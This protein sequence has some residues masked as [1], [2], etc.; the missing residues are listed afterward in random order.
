ME[1]VVV[2]PQVY[3]SINNTPSRWIIFPVEPASVASA[4]KLAGHSVTG[5]DLNLLPQPTESAL[6]TKIE[7]IKPD[8]VVFIP[9]WLGRYDMKA[10]DPASFNTVKQAHPNCIRINTG[11][12]ATLYPDMELKSGLPFEYGLR[13]EVEETLVELLDILDK[14]GN[15]A[16]IPG[17]FY[18]ADKSEFISEKIPSF[19]LKRM[20]AVDETVFPRRNYLDRVERG[21]FRFPRDGQPLTYN[22]TSRGCHYRC[23]FCSVIYLR[24][25]SFRQK[26]MDVIFTEIEN[27]LAAG[28]KEVHFLDELFGSNRTFLE[29]F[30]TEVKRRGLE[31]NW[32]AT[33]G[34]PVGYLDLELLKR[35]EES[36]MYRVKIPF[37]SANSRVLNKLLKKPN[38]VAQGWDV[39]RAVKKTG[40]ETIA[41]FLVGMPG[42]SKKE[43][44]QT[45]AMAQDIGFDYTL[46][47]IATPMGGSQLERE[48]LEHGLA[49]RNEIREKIRGDS[50]FFETDELKERDLFEVR[51]KI[52]SDINFAT[53]AKVRKIA[54]MFG[55]SENEA[56]KMEEV[57]RQ[58]FQKYTKA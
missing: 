11:V 21:N 26:R 35:L 39:A 30:C 14:G 23:K 50:V 33:C 29:Q 7:S 53:A 36:G 32:F 27:S 15:V 1:V 55:I 18:V 58:R 3:N 13:G 51:W 2:V 52:W 25:Y 10:V 42:E 56:A 57:A 22:Q 19:D 47:S 46:F 28:A 49:N 34:L 4:I 44:A 31:F 5:I 54:K 12:Q 43:M 41:A 17:I 16:Q 38:S 20:E 8:V 45:V 9:Q 24:D 37:E 48:V 6:F 40:L